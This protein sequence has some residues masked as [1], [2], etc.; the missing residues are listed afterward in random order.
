MSLSRNEI[1]ER[2]GEIGCIVAILIPLILFGG[3]Y[4]WIISSFRQL[5]N[6]IKKV[7]AKSAERRKVKQI[8]N[9]KALIYR[10]ILAKE[11]IGIFTGIKEVDGKAFTNA[12]LIETV[13][14]FSIKY[15]IESLVNWKSEPNIE[16]IASLDNKSIG[17]KN[18]QI[19]DREG[20]SRSA[21]RFIDNK[22]GCQIEILISKEESFKSVS[23]VKEICNVK[24]KEL[25]PIMR[26]K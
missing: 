3:Y 12:L 11:K 18:W 13:D 8:E 23:I 25:T 5:G 24:T 17:N 16:G 26:F 4:F 19:K 10:E 15:R 22:E 6:S 9:E 7:G 21:F 20:S 14:S 1:K 2:R